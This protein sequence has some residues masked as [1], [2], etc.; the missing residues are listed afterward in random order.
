MA[1][2]R[3]TRSRKSRA[4]RRFR[5]SRHT[6][7][8]KS[9]RNTAMFRSVGLPRTLSVKFPWFQLR[10]INPQGQYRHV[11]LGNSLDPMPQ[12]LQGLVGTTPTATVGPVDSLVPGIAQYSALYGASNVSFSKWTIRIQNNL[13]RH[14]TVGTDVVT[15]YGTCRVVVFVVPYATPGV[16]DNTGAPDLSDR[17]IQLDGLTF[18]DCCAQPYAKVFNLNGQNSGHET[19][20]FKISRRT[21][22][23]IGVTNIRDRLGFSSQTLPINS[24][25][26]PPDPLPEEGWLIYMRQEVTSAFDAPSA[27]EYDIKGTIYS[28]LSIRDMV[29]LATPN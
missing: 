26:A 3:A 19:H 7:R 12:G 28:T 15:T 20:T 13:Q 29:P 24:T 11:I 18:T 9:N 27:M 5:K 21:K 23:M 22:S 17:I 14:E 8:P 2:R 6:R 1:R 4:P 16:Y 10:Q 25:V